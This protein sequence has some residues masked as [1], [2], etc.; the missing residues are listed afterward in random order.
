MWEKADWC[1]RRWSDG[2]GGG[3]VIIGEWNELYR[4]TGEYNDS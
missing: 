3:G 2:V 1:G 4:Y